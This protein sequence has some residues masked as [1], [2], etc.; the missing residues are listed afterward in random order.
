MK[1]NTTRPRYTL[2]WN[3]D[4]VV[5]DNTTGQQVGICWMP[6][7]VVYEKRD[8]TF[9]IKAACKK[10]KPKRGFPSGSEPF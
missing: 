3:K 7:V 8:G 4:L 5:I 10:Q 1:K 9:G 2:A 6:S